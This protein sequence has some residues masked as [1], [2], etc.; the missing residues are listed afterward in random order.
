MRKND[1]KK[2]ICSMI[3]TL[4]IGAGFSTAGNINVKANNTHTENDIVE[5]R[6]KDKYFGYSEY[7]TGL[8]G[9]VIYE[10]EKEIKR[11]VDAG[12]LSKNL[13]DLEIKFLKSTNE[14]YKNHIY[15]QIIDLTKNDYRFT[16]NELN[17][18]KDGGYK[19][20]YENLDRLYFQQLVDKGY[21]SQEELEIEIKLNAAKNKDEKEEAYRLLIDNLIMKNEITKEQGE[22][23]IKDGYDNFLENME[24][25]QYENVINEM[26]KEGYITKEKAEELKNKKDYDKW[27]DEFLRLYDMY[28]MKRGV[29]IEILNEKEMDVFKKILNSELGYKVDD[30]IDIY[31]IFNSVKKQ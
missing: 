14:D 1:L 9:I 13:A 11:L 6:F 23:F 12:I 3:L 31:S 8:D 15:K 20:Y 7:G 17:K 26:E 2:V 5:N 18:L 30:T 19:N 10:N 27:N 25:V 22:K 24:Y 29:E 4:L 21:M 28:L 16:Y